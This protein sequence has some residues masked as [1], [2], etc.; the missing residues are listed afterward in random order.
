MVDNQQTNPQTPVGATYSRI[1]TTEVTF[2]EIWEVWL[3]N[4]QK[5]PCA[6]RLESVRKVHPATLVDGK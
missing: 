6:L 1:G 4:L 2:L 5:P 3:P